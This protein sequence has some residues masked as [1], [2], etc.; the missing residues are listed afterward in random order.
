MGT[1]ETLEQ[2]QKTSYIQPTHPFRLQSVVVFVKLPVSENRE[3]RL[4]PALHMRE[5]FNRFFT[6][7]F[8]QSLFWKKG[9]SNLNFVCST[10]E[11][12]KKIS[13]CLFSELT[14]CKYNSRLLLW[15]NLAISQ[16]CFLKAAMRSYYLRALVM[17]APSVSNRR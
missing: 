17:I 9:S 5:F 8:R 3:H 7:N 4:G 2:L 11:V 14:Y 1:V 10:R 13:S 6:D 12:T 15:K 16:V